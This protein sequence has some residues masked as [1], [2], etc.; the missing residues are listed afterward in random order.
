MIKV[1]QWIYHSNRLYKVV[2]VEKLK[3]GVKAGLFHKE[4]GLTIFVYYQKNLP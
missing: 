4:T 2:S 1:G 3:F